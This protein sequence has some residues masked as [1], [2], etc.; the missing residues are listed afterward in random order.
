MAFKA[1]SESS[2]V[3]PLQDRTCSISQW[4]KLQCLSKCPDFWPSEQKLLVPIPRKLKNSWTAADLSHRLSVDEIKHKWL[5]GR[6]ERLRDATDDN[7]VGL[8]WTPGVPLG[9]KFM[10]FDPKKSLFIFFCR[11]ATKKQL[12]AAHKAEREKKIKVYRQKY[13]VFLQVKPVTNS[14]FDALIAAT[15]VCSSP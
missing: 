1:S 6:E 7:A 4:E 10:E 2:K 9:F 8:L 12:E 15:Q 13:D 14:P 11:I 5:H 3:A